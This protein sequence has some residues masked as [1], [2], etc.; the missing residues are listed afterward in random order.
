MDVTPPPIAG[1]DV[2]DATPPPIDVTPSPLHGDVGSEVPWPFWPNL[3][4]GQARR[5]TRELY[6]SS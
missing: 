2:Q 4:T 1:Q 5:R 3:V 6:S